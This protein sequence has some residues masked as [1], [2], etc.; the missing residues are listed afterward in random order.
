MHVLGHS[1]LIEIKKLCFF[2]KGIGSR[3]S[4]E[5]EVI[6]QIQAVALLVLL[7]NLR[8]RSVILMLLEKAS[9]I[10]N[11]RRYHKKTDLSV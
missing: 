9:K 4:E 3:P 7:S 8:S 10:S 5:E 2:Q 6:Q 1:N 11:Q